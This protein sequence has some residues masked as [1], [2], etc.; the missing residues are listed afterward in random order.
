MRFGAGGWRRSTR[1]G[2]FTQNVLPR[3]VALEV[4]RLTLR[5][6][7]GREPLF[8]SRI[9]RGFVVD[10]HRDLLADD[11]FCLPDGPRILD[12][13]D[14]D[15]RLRYRDGPDDA[16]FLGMDLERLSAPDLAATFLGWYV[17]FVGDPCRLPEGALRARLDEAHVHRA[18]GSRGAAAISRRVRRHGR[19]LDRPALARSRRGSCGR[20]ARRP[21]RGALRGTAR[22]RCR[23]PP[24]PHLGYPMLTRPSPQ[25]C[26]PTP[27]R[28]RRLSPPTRPPGVEETARRRRAR[29]ARIRPCGPGWPG[30]H[31]S[32]PTE[33]RRF[34]QRLASA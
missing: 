16:A 7:E 10:G 3:R 17:E 4:E 6:L 14:F 21:G 34:G 13:L 19:V 31:R 1:Y 33:Q 11:I 9:E 5:Y 32:N 8:A 20:S 28:G 18:V 2:A 15:D 30:A 25:R 12:C 29:Q 22:D 23:T 26:T 24:Q 27:N